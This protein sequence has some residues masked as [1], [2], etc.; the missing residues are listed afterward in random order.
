MRNDIRGLRGRG[1][2]MFNVWRIL[3]GR[4]VGFRIDRR[5]II[6]KGRLRERRRKWKINYKGKVVMRGRVVLK[7]WGKDWMFKKKIMMK[8]EKMLKRIE[9]MREGKEI[10]WKI[11]NEKNGKKML[12]KRNIKI[13]IRRKG[14]K[15]IVKRE[16]KM[17]EIRRKIRSW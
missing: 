12:K 5:R 8:G 1:G 13:G 14:W 9:G 16:D 3:I 7:L 11:I 17:E 6:K 2:R 10:E 4:K 15:N